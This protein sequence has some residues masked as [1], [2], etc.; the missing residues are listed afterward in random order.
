MCSI[1]LWSISVRVL[2]NQLT[3]HVMLTRLRHSTVNRGEH[4][5]FM[6]SHKP[7]TRQ[8]KL[9]WLTECSV[10]RRHWGC[11]TKK[12]FEHLQEEAANPDDV[13]GFDELRPDDQE[14]IRKAYEDGGSKSAN[15]ISNSHTVS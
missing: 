5:F 7:R 2:A 12:V 1:R 14:R 8:T 4:Y 3:S 11:V 6:V 15:P 13:D 10:S 9:D